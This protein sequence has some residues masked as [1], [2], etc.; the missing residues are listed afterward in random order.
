M[1]PILIDTQRPVGPDCCV[2]CYYKA[3]TN[4]LCPTHVEIP[5]KNLHLKCQFEVIFG[6][7]GKTNLLEY[8]TNHVWIGE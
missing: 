5:L 6:E 8:T 1:L 2:G 7:G 3:P 4:A